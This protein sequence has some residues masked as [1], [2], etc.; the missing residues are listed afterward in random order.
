MKKNGKLLIVRNDRIGDVVLSL[1]LARIVKEHYPE[2]SV[3]FLVREYTK[4]LAE[5]NPFIDKILILKE[6]KGNPFIFNNASLIRKNNF[7][8]CIIVSP[9]FKLA[10]MLFLSGIQE[11][12]GTGYRWYSFLFNKKVYE[13]RKNSNRH[14]LEYNINLLKKIGIDKTVSPE[15]IVFDIN[16]KEQYSYKIE[17]FLSEK[18][19][20]LSKKNIIIHPGSGGSAVDLPLEKFKELVMQLSLLTNCNIIITGSLSEKKM[21]EELV[22]SKSVF[23]FAGIFNLSELTALINKADL[24]IANSTGPLHIAAALGKKVIGFYPKIKWCSPERWG[25]YT[26]NK[27]IFVP[28]INCSNC[29]REQCEKLN[30]MNTIRIERIIEEIK[31]IVNPL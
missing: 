14:E 17:K 1:P 31:K 28:E 16:I 23:N 25:P 19:I 13:H 12:I 22:V 11:R 21:C 3:S 24:F 30:C 6:E 10:L 5:N 18:G 7:D 29:T 20:D 4:P 15:N 9:T 27:I 2:C 8:T 26:M